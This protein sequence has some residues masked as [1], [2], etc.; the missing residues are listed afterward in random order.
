MSGTNHRSY[1]RFGGEQ[2]KSMGFLGDH[3]DRGPVARI[4]E[5]RSLLQLFRVSISFHQGVGRANKTDHDRG[6]R[7]AL[8]LGDDCGADSNRSSV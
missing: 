1:H 6:L 5:Y 2:T 3:N 4:M 7:V 8:G